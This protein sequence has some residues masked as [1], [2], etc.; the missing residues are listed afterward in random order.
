LR[1]FHG[2]PQ[3]PQQNDGPRFGAV[4]GVPFAVKTAEFVALFNAQPE[5]RMECAFG[6]QIVSL[7]LFSLR[8]FVPRM[9]LI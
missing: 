1:L 5:R 3:H 8:S 2:N 4:H 6:A 7:G 9:L